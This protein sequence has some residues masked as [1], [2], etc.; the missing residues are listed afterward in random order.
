MATWLSSKTMITNEGFLMLSYAQSGIEGLTITR[1][2]IGSTFSLEADLPT[3]T[4]I[5]DVIGEPSITNK[6]SSV[7]GSTITL[8]LTNEGV[9]TAYPICQ[10]GIYATHPSV[11]DGSEYLYY[12]SQSEDPSDIMPRAV[13]SLIQLTYKVYIRHDSASDVTIQLN[14]TIVPTAS[15]T[16]IGGVMIGESLNIDAEGV[17]EIAPATT[18]TYGGVIIGDNLYLNEAGALSTTGMIKYRILT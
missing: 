6:V 17:V 18:T 9:L 1:A 16:E 14:E 3:L 11:D 10:I 13:D 5:P 4:A 7:D 12:I 8:L 15:D 2:E